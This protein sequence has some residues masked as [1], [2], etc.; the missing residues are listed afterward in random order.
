MNKARTTENEA[1]KLSKETLDAMEELGTVLKSI[2]LRL[3]N[4]GFEMEDGKLVKLSE[5]EQE[6]KNRRGNAK[7]N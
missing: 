4:E 2:Y 6:T 5:N 3:K 7:G 1:T